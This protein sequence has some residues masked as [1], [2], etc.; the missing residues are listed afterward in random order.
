VLDQ[1]AVVTERL[2]IVEVGEGGCKNETNKEVLLPMQISHLMEKL[3]QA[4]VYC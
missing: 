4:K 1:A 3:C 2:T